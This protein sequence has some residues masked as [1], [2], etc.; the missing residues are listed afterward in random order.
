MITD[1]CQVARLTSEMY[2]EPAADLNAREYSMF[3]RME[4]RPDPHKR[5]D[6]FYVALLSA[7]QCTNDT[8]AQGC[9]HI[10]AQL[11]AERTAYGFAEGVAKLPPH[12][13]GGAVCHT[14]GG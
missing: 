6:L 10:A 4:K 9:A 7:E 11:F 1:I 14:L 13:T 2:H 12:S 3:I 8:P 5:S